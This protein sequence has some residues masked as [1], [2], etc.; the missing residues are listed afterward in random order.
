MIY[1]MKKDE[2]EDLAI[3][4]ANL[5]RGDTNALFN[6]YK[7][8][9][10]PMFNYG[11]SLDRIRENVDDAISE[12]F[13]ELWENRH[14]LKPVS[15]VKSY[16]FTYLRRKI[17]RQQVIGSRIVIPEAELYEQSIMEYLVQLQLHEERQQM[18]MTAINKLTPRQKQ[19]IIYKFY[20]NLQY[21]QISEKTGLATQTI[22]NNIHQAL[23]SLRAELKLPM[24]VLIILLKAKF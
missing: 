1:A 16:L 13:L 9:F 2:A 21:E 20:Q 24:A 7:Q 14:R 19:L 17:G 11:Y 5:R 15:N 12:V 22:Y 4:W 6:L 8:L 10:N 23:S 18:I 3:Q